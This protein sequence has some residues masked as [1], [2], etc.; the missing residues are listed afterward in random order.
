MQRALYAV[1]LGL[2]LAAVSSSPALAFPPET[3][4]A[5]IPFAFSVDNET[6]P[7]GEYQ[8][9]P[10]SDLDRQVLEVRSTDGRHAVLVFTQDGS[11]ARSTAA[12]RLIFDSYGQMKFLHAIR[13]PDETAAVLQA[14]RSEVEAARDAALARPAR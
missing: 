10:V 6:L 7:P 9:N 4:V 12:P 3:V 1:A 8:I 11:T 2:G 5:N 14:S 13:L